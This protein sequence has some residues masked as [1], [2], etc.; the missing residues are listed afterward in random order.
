MCNLA[1]TR[2]ISRLEQYKRANFPSIPREVPRNHTLENRPRNSVVG[3]HE[4]TMG[5]R[6]ITNAKPEI[7]DPP[8][9]IGLKSSTGRL[10]VH[11][12]IL[13]EV[14]APESL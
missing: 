8:W 14:T 9:A 13:E 2:Y 11:A 12:G 3:K 4:S 6:N 10:K 1:I 5:C 7:I